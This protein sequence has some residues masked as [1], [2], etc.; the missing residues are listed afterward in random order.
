MKTTT[1]YRQEAIEAGEDG[2]WMDAAL[3]WEKAIAVANPQT[4]RERHDVTIMQSK[5]DACAW[6]VRLAN[7][8]GQMFA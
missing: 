7:P 1:E 8:F 4:Q 3:L 2:R 5:M 6:K